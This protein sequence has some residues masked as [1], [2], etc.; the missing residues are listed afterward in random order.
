MTALN[1]VNGLARPLVSR[2]DSWGDHLAPF[3]DLAVRLGL[4]WIFYKSG[5]NKFQ[6]WDTTVFLFEN[7]YAVPL[8][9]PNL[10]AGLATF[11]ELVMPVLLAIGL[12]G[13]FA[14]FVLFVFNIVAVVSYPALNLH[15]Q[16]DHLWWGALLLIPVLRGPGTW[17]I[18]HFIRSRYLRV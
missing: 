5:L 9:A 2:L 15:G 12:A 8:L 6:S 14:A 18:D 16:L 7:E 17:S 3:F 11:V 10:A 1:T 4:A 13:R